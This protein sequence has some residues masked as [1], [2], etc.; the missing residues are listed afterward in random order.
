V[1]VAAERSE[2]VVVGAAAAGVGVAVVEVA[3]VGG[4]AQGR[5]GDRPGK[6]LIDIRWFAKHPGDVDT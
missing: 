1:V 3:V 5:I 4:H 2:V 6:P